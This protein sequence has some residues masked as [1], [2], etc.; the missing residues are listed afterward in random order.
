MAPL[1]P[2]EPLAPAPQPAA[3]PAR[4]AS[5]SIAGSARCAS[6]PA[7]AGLLRGMRV[8]LAGS[9][10]AQQIEELLAHLPLVKDAAQRGGDG[11]R[12]GLLDAAH[13]DAEVARLDHHHRS[14]RLQLLVEEGDDLL[15]DPLLQ[16]R[17]LGVELE[18]ARKLRQAEDPVARDV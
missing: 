6:A 2:T 18:D 3:A 12:P 17:A 13:L 10:M 14:L 15:G 4:Q 1:E 8:A 11:Q 7:R 9:L 16:L 5:A